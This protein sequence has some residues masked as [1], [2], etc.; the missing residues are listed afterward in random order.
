V[1]GPGW[2]S[3][4]ALGVDQLG[5]SL[6]AAKLIGVPTSWDKVDTEFVVPVSRWGPWL[7]SLLPAASAASR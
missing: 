3:M 1:I 2:I 4:P 5:V 6:T 7:S